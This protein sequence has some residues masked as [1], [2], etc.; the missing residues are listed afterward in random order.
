MLV[1]SV[2]LLSLGSPTIAA[3]K[4]GLVHPVERDIK[5]LALDQSVSLIRG[6]AMDT[7]I[8]VAEEVAEVQEHRIAPGNTDPVGQRTS[9][10]PVVANT[11]L[12]VASVGSGA[13]S[14]WSCRRMAGV[15]PCCRR[16]IFQVFQ[17]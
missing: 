2:L 12:F 10:L 6:S 8:L 16:L 4:G 14:H 9:S 3:C 7:T 17:L 1:T 11:V 15:V 5:A 13:S